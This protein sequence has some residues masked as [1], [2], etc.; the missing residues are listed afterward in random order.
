MPSATSVR[1]GATNPWL[2]L[3]VL[4]GA[5]LITGLDNTI[6]NV[7]LPTI[8]RDLD[9]ST[10]E[11]QWVVDSYTVMFA[12]LLVLAGTLGDRF[13]R[14]RIF[15]IGLIV[16]A[17]GSLAGTLATTA[18]QLSA[19]RAI[20]GIGGACIMPST[21]SIIVQNF[22]DARSRAQAIGIWAGVSGLGVAIGPVIGGVLLEHFHWNSVFAVN[23]PIALVV[24]AAAIF[25][26]PESRDPSKPRLDL[27]GAGLWAVGLIC[28]VLTIIRLPDTGLT[29]PTLLILLVSGVAL[30]AFVLWERRAP[31]PLVPL[32][33]FANPTFSV[34]LTLVAM[35][36]FALFGA[37]FFFPQ[38]LQLVKGLSPLQSGLTLVPA[39]LCLTLAATISPGL[40]QRL[41]SRTMVVIGLSAVT[42]GLAGAS[43]FV[44]DTSGWQVAA[45]M[46]LVGL[47]MGLTLPHATNGVLSCV[48]KERAGIG[49]AM[50]ETTGEVGG[51]LGVAVL[52]AL[53]STAYRARI[54]QAV[55]DAGAAAAQVPQSVIDAVR[56]SLA[57]A[58]LVAGQSPQALREAITS[59]AGSAFVSGMDTAVWVGACVTAIGAV[60]AAFVFPKRLAQVAE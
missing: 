21:L 16:F 7:A 18:G 34:S 23:P 25:L 5:L 6:V 42:V 38:F 2:V 35:L 28:L 51:A 3:A 20:M 40:A 57:A 54:D 47:G 48:P 15:L 29:V 9:A 32:R 8:Q 11:L 33:L 43:M 46:S 45:T 14:K 12:G 27:L 26:V 17:L 59:I 50:N 31:R 1:A 19:A 22:P 10:A 41:G 39:A 55:V 49:S 56:D 37:M 30:I 4:C 13:G 52:G 58:S 36:Y 53:L 60:I 24:L 44:S